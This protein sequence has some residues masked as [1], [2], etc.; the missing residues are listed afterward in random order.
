VVR[1]ESPDELV[2]LQRG[3]PDLEQQYA[4]RAAADDTALA[5]DSGIVPLVFGAAAVEF[6]GANFQ[7]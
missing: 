5:V 2:E 3:L 4:P 6:A 1:I 7:G